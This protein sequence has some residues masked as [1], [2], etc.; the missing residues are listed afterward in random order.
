MDCGNLSGSDG[1]DIK[2]GLGVGVLGSGLKSNRDMGLGSCVCRN[3]GFL[4]RI[5]MG[6]RGVEGSFI[7]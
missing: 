3:S 2:N 4:D 6:D 7:G 5:G 1:V